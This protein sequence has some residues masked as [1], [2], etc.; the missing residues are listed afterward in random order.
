[1][2]SGNV[3]IGES[4]FIGVNATFRDGIVVAPE[5]VIGAGALIMKN[6]EH[7]GVYAP[8]GTE[9]IGRKSW[10]LRNF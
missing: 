1:M 8:R 10:D 7:G 9:P 3:Q 2:I 6:T 5:C 4:C